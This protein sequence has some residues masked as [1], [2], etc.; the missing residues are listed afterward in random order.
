MPTFTE[1]SPWGKSRTHIMK[2]AETNSNKSWSFGKSR[3]HKSR[4]SW[5]QTIS[6]C[7][8]VCDSLWQVRNKPVCVTLTEFSPLQYM[9][10]VGN[11]VHTL[12]LRLCRKHKSRK[13]VTW[14]T[15]VDHVIYVAN[16]HDVCR[17][18]VGVMEFGL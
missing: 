13:S 1:T 2:V 17:R 14:S 9:G 8:D 3:E 6:T 12:C 5:T 4:K 15:K 16:F 10:K 18:K 7:R 11:K